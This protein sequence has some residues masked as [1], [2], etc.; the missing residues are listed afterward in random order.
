MTSDRPYLLPLGFSLFFSMIVFAGSG[1]GD[2]RPKISTLADKLTKEKKIHF[3]YAVGF[4]AIPETKNKY[5]KLY[6]KLKAK[7]TNEELLALTKNNSTTI[8][9][10]SF[11]ILRYRNYEGLKNVFFEHMNDTTWYWTAGGCTGVLNTVNRFML[12]QLR[13]TDAKGIKNYFTKEEFEQY[14][15][16]FKKEYPSIKL[17]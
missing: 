15:N 12:M 9:I 7:A 3:G 2:I 10:Y 6:L 11:D 14:L 8:L 4:S 5:Y 16:R 13:P 17:D 1:Q